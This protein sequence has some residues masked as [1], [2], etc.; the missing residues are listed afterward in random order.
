[1]NAATQTGHF[2]RQPRKAAQ[3]RP[4]DAIMRF[5]RRAILALQWFAVVL[6]TAFLVAPTLL[7]VCTVFYAGPGR[8]GESGSCG[9][10]SA[11]NKGKL[12]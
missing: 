3:M 8:A 2:M 9:G 7:I 11:R 1:M 12:T 6:Y 5:H 4:G 10:A